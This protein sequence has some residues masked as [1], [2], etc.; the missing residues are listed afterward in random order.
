MMKT[1]FIMVLTLAGVYC[2]DAK[3]ANTRY[4]VVAV[5]EVKNDLTTVVLSATIHCD[6]CKKKIEKNMAFEKGVKEIKVDV[7]SKTI[8]ITFKSNKNT[9]EGIKKSLKKLGYDSE[10]KIVK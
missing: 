7:N 1:I 2:N 8:T 10:I 6:N 3:A 5:K 9:P 4:D